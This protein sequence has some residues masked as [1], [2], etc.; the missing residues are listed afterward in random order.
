[1][2][3]K[4]IATTWKRAGWMALVLLGLLGGCASTDPR[5]PLEPVNRKVQAFNDTLDDYLMKPLARGYQW[6][7]PDFVD[8]GVTNFFG[9]VKDIAVTANDL[10]Q[11]KFKQSGQDA[12]RFLVNTTVGVAGLID[13]ASE[14]GLEKHDEDFGQTLGVWGLPPGPYLVLP[15]LGPTTPRDGVGSVADGF[16]NP[17]AYTIFPVKV[18]LFGLRTVDYRADN[19]SS[20]EILDQAALDRYAFIRNAYLQR[21]EYLIHDGEVPLDEEFE[22]LEEELDEGSGESGI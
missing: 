6:V 4:T 7:T 14:I 2:E 5:D 3:N 17:I 18:G 9:N 8:Q 20:T 10:L 15:F 12:A 16:M 13:V 19:L 11:F 21:R 22:E 1:M